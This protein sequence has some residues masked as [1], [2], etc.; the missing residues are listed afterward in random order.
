MQI[1]GWEKNSFVDFPGRISCVIFAPG[2]NFNCWYCHNA[3]IKDE[4]INFAEILEF[5]ERRKTDTG[6]M[7]ISTPELT[8]FDLVRHSSACGGLSSV[9]TVLAELSESIDFRKSEGRVLSS[10]SCATIQRLGYILDTVISQHENADVLY[11]YWRQHFTRSNYV[12]LASHVAV[13]SSNRDKRWKVLVNV[14][15][16][17]DEL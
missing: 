8:A 5:L 16:E 9:A 12:P 15:M 6:Y 3:G 1:A 13:N 2:C 10:T 11:G 14:E 17:I 4:H 7:S